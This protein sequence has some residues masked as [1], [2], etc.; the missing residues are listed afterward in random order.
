MTRWM[1]NKKKT[2][3]D[4]WIIS[5]QYATFCQSWRRHWTSPKVDISRCDAKQLGV[6]ENRWCSYI[7]MMEDVAYI[8]GAV[9]KRDI[10]LNDPVKMVYRSTIIEK[11]S[12]HGIIKVRKDGTPMDIEQ[13]TCDAIIGEYMQK[14][15]WIKTTKAAIHY[16]K[17]G[18]HLV[19][20]KGN[21]YD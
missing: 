2:G 15:E 10:Y 1:L 4:R 3:D 16:G 13:I 7:E 5:G 8:K 6:S 19:P 21:H 17:K 9:I 12:G 20:I 11:Y 14:G 18:A